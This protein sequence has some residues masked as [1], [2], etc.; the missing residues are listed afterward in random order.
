[1][2]IS[3]FP[4]PRE[5]YNEPSQSLEVAAVAGEGLICYR[6]GFERTENDSVRPAGTSPLEQQ[7]CALVLSKPMRSVQATRHVSGTV[8]GAPKSG[9][10]SGQFRYARF[11]PGTLCMRPQQSLW[12][13]SVWRR[14]LSDRYFDMKRHFLGSRFHLGGLFNWKGS[15]RK[16][17]IAEVVRRRA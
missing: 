12:G 2:I 15:G 1:M 13:Y 6:A 3:P 4:P 9:S 10:P 14:W 5:R 17:K 16:A 8:F 7:W 11:R